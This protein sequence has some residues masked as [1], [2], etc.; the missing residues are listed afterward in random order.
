MQYGFI[1]RNVTDMRAEPAFRSERKSQLLY[2]EPIHYKTVRNGYLLAFQDDGYTGWVDRRAVLAVEKNDWEKYKGQ[3]TWNVR[4]LTARI[5]PVEKSDYLVPPYIFYGSS[6]PKVNRKG[7]R[8]Y[9]R[10]A[11]NAIYHT[12]LKSIE[13]TGA[14]IESP[15]AS[16]VKEARRFLGTPYLWGGVTPFGID[17]S[18]LVQMIYR[19][20]G[21]YLPRDSKDQARCGR[22]I[23]TEDCR[24]GD[25][26]FFKGH[27]AIAMHGQNIIHASLAEGGVAIN[28]L[29]PDKSGFRPDLLDIFI[30]ARRV[31]P[32]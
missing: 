30:S 18:G 19:R 8:A 9:F 23:S 28:S 21:I 16:I 7:N 20:H 25:L 1:I 27:V 6:L 31:L 12:N 15:G 10:I 24:P 13:K 4:A 32:S 5:S 14:E 29:N 26:L 11:N 3:L 2:N 17:C 22:V